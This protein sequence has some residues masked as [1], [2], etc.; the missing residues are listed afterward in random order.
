MTKATQWFQEAAE[1][2]GIAWDDYQ[3][4]RRIYLRAL[5]DLLKEDEVV[6]QIEKNLGKSG[7]AGVI[8]LYQFGTLNNTG[9]ENVDD[10]IASGEFQTLSVE[11]QKLLKMLCSYA[12][13]SEYDLVQAAD[14]LESVI[15]DKVR[16]PL[17]ETE[18]RYDDVEGWLTPPTTISEEGNR[19]AEFLE[20]MLVD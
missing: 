13:I 20:K 4:A 2:V 19:I 9:R 15:I 7:V 1:I 14:E 16:V 12:E 10:W 11:P 5:E 18:Y 3:K 6:E 17:V 8:A